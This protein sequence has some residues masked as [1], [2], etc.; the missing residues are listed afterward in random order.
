MLERRGSES[1][2]SGEQSGRKSRAERAALIQI[3]SRERARASLAAR[4]SASARPVEDK[5]RLER[6]LLS[7]VALAFL[8]SAR[9]F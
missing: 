2:C 9:G 4:R 5:E 1:I 6:A 3:A 7:R 8:S